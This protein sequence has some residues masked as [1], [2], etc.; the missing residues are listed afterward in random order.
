MKLINL[1]RFIIKIKVNEQ[2]VVLRPCKTYYRC[3]VNTVSSENIVLDTGISIPLLH[4]AYEVSPKI[5]DPKPDT[6]YIVSKTIFIDAFPDRSD[7]VTPLW[8][9]LNDYPVGFVC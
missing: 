2:F 3:T 6:Y 4:R 1:T 7:L 5:P 8:D 9:N